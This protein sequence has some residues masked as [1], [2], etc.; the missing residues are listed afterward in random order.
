MTARLEWR[1]GAICMDVEETGNAKDHLMR[2]CI[3]WGLFVEHATPALTR[4]PLFPDMNL[5]HSRPPCLF[6]Q[7]TL[8]LSW[9]WFWLVVVRVSITTG[10]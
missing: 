3:E 5:Y 9:I 4:W 6:I 8:N 2:L 1:I 10:A 7:K